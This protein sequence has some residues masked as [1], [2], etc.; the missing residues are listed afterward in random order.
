[1]VSKRDVVS[2][3]VAGASKVEGTHGKAEGEDLLDIR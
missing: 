3:G 1:M 2:F